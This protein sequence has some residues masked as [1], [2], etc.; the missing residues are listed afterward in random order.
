MSLVQS[1]ATSVKLSM[2]NIEDAVAG[3]FSAQSAQTAADFAALAKAHDDAHHAATHAR[4]EA[5]VARM[6]E[7][8]TVRAAKEAEIAAVIGDAADGSGL[9]TILGAYKL[10]TEND[11]NAEATLNAA[12]AIEIQQVADYREELGIDE[13]DAILTALSTDLGL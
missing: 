3:N 8:A 4:E 5:H 12:N 13:E 2:K 7:I 9:N 11:S 6:D 1:L 10:F